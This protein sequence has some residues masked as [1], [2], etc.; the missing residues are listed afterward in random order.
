MKLWDRIEYSAIIDREP[1]RLPDL[2]CW[3][4]TDLI[5]SLEGPTNRQRDPERRDGLP[6][7]ETLLAKNF[8]SKVRL[9]SFSF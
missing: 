6:I 3:F 7:F 4:W 1:L 5:D 8:F 2:P 9:V